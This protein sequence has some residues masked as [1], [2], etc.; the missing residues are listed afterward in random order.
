M[1]CV[2]LPI[3]RTCSRFF[4][5]TAGGHLF[6]VSRQEKN[7]SAEIQLA[8]W[9]C[10][11]RGVDD[12][13]GPAAVTRALA[14]RGSVSTKRADAATSQA[15]FLTKA[16]AI[17]P[18]KGGG[19]IRGLGEKFAANPVTGA[20]S[21]SVPIAT[22]PGRSGTGPQ[23][24]PNGGC[25]APVDRTTSGDALFGARDCTSHGHDRSSFFGLFSRGR[26]AERWEI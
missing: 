17:S 19:A 2:Q 20:G 14:E 11:M 12:Q 1:P 22:S 24:S 10:E 9:R 26:S 13:S 4:L 21:I 6:A 23:L 18:P 16:S 8:P 7:A 25:L 5:E 15:G 3:V